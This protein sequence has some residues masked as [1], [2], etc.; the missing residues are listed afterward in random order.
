MISEA[1]PNITVKGRHTGSKP[2]LRMIG[3]SVLLLIVVAS[4]LAGGLLGEDSTGGMRF[5]FYT[6]HWLTIK[7]FS[8]MP[9]RAALADYYNPENPLLYMIASLLPLHGD[10]KLYHAITFTA[11]LLIWPLLSSAYYCRYRKFGID[12][13]WASFGASAILLSPTFR[14]STFWGNTDWLPFAFCAITSLLLSRF[15][16]C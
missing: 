11:G 16:R 12:W 9:W 14:S 6:T 3:L 5:D 1:G 8:T 4:F 7:R 15:P 2:N 13:L 10:P